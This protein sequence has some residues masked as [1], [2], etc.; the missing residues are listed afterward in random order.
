M[1]H[2]CLLLRNVVLPLAVVGGVGVKEDDV[3]VSGV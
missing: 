2:G 1:V 3:V